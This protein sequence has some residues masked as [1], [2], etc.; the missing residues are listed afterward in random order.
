MSPPAPDDLAIL[1]VDDDL[2]MRAMLREVLVKAGFEVEEAATS[3]ELLALVPRVEP[4]AIILDHEMPGSW[5]LEVLPALRKAYPH[6][7]VIFTT[8]FGSGPM[9][10]RATRAGAAACLAKP[11]R[12]GDMLR[13]VARVLRPAASEPDLRAS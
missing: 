10:E 13:T 11:F 6:V 5:G 4:A 7:P 2:D 9:W 12:L 8:A 3:D 1:I